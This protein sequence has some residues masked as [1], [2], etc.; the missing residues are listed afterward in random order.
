VI[1]IEEARQYYEGNDAAHDFD[2]VLRVRA[3]AERI[4]QEEGADIQIVCAAALLHD[5]GRA[6][7]ELTGRSHAEL[8]EEQ[9]RHI[10]AGHPPAEVRAVCQAIAAHR[11][12]D[13]VVPQTLEARVLYDADKLDSIGAVGIARAYLYGG[14]RKQRLWGQ[15]PIGHQAW[16][17]TGEEHTPAHEFAFK[18]S[19]VKDSLYTDSARRIGEARHAYMAEFFLRLGSE[20]LGEM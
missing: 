19:R 18:L 4:A 16:S 8:G 10:L 2:H 9:A 5:V 11:F 1:T 3:L 7:Q 14:V 12:R 20:L 13:D 15:V 17:D 6:E